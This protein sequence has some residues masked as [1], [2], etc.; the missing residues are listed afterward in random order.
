MSDTKTRTRQNYS[1]YLTL[2]HKQGKKQEVLLE[3][4][5]MHLIYEDDVLPLEWLCKVYNEAVVEGSVFPPD[6]EGKI[7][8]LNEK[9]LKLQP[10]SAMGLFTKSVLL[11]NDGQVSDAVSLLQKGMLI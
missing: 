7:V 10:E 6:I 1:E 2:L 9:L 11:F 8:E 5:K 4:E 3:A